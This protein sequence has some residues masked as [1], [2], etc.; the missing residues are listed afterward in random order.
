MNAKT[1]RRQG[2]KRIEGRESSGDGTGEG[3]V[4]SLYSR[5]TIITSLFSSLACWRLGV[6]LPLVPPGKVAT[7]SPFQPKQKHAE[8]AADAWLTLTRKTLGAYGEPGLMSLIPPH[9]GQLVNRILSP[10]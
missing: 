9:G 3:P 2:G 7:V 4:A 5:H 8:R 1:P 6:H 10:D